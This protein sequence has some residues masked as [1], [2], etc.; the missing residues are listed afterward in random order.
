ME[1]WHHD[2]DAAKGVG[3]EPNE[4]YASGIVFLFHIV[5]VFSTPAVM[6]GVVFS[7]RFFL[8]FLKNRVRKKYIGTF[9]IYFYFLRKKRKIK[10]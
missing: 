1:R 6:V 4:Y 8:F 3:V 10:K 5:Y 2:L 9:L 7:S